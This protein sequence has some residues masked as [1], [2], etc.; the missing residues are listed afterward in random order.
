MA[1]CNVLDPVGSFKAGPLPAFMKSADTKQT[2]IYKHVQIRRKTNPLLPTAALQLLRCW[3]YETLTR[4]GP[5]PG[6]GPCHTGR[7]PLTHRT[8][9]SL[10]T[11]APR[12]GAE[13]GSSS[14]AGVRKDVSVCTV[15]GFTERM[16]W[17]SLHA[18]YWTSRI[19]CNRASRGKI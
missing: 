10:V 3:R 8:P 18:Y 19:M 1:S 11:L 6:P 4:T 2:R 9:I 13:T 14:T 7:A 16:L 12:T 15:G 17:A 5:Q